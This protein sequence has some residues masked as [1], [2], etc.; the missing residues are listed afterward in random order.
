MVLVG[1]DEKDPGLLDDY[2]LE[3]EKSVDVSSSSNL[4][5]PY[6]YIYLHL[7]VFI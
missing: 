4:L 6:M 1:H 7:S 2:T 5:M 3:L